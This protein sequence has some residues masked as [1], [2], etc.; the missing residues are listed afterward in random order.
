M[1]REV[2]QEPEKSFQD[3]SLGFAG[4]NIKGYLWTQGHRKKVGNGRLTKDGGTLPGESGI[5][6]GQRLLNK[7]GSQPPNSP[8]NLSCLSGTR[9]CS[10][11][12]LRRIHTTYT[13]RRKGGGTRMGGS[14][15]LYRKTV[16]PSHFGR[17]HRC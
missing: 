5:A 11:G 1:G 17:T 2:C 14:S 9:H 12:H 16:N 4:C 13:R 15:G 10:Q 7:A 3:T 6:T 8:M